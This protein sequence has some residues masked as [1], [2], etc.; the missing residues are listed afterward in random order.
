MKIC[1]R[2]PS[3]KTR[4]FVLLAAKVHRTFAYRSRPFLGKGTYLI[5]FLTLTG[6]LNLCLYYHICKGRT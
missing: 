5:N 2:Y 4:H 6:I 1:T 3:P